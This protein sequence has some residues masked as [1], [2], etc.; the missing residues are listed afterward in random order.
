MES[1]IY[2]GSRM[3]IPNANTISAKPELEDQLSS[4]E[5]ADI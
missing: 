4:C 5:E 1:E 3:N 2:L